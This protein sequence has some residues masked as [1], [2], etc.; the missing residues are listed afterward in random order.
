MEMIF[1]SHANKTHFHKKGCALG[2]I[3]KVRLFGTPKLLDEVEQNIVICQWRIIRRKSLQGLVSSPLIRYS[4]TIFRVILR[5][6]MF[7]EGKMIIYI[8]I[9]VINSSVEAFGC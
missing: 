3:L 9:A 6:K 8:N 2:L 5:N 1:H 4:V 7:L